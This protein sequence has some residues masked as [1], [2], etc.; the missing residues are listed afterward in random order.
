VEL[1]RNLQV[2][3]TIPHPSPLEGVGGIS[4]KLKNSSSSTLP[5]IE[6]TATYDRYEK[7]EETVLEATCRVPNHKC[8]ATRAE[9]YRNLHNWY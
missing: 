9:Q 8:R 7:G 3:C 5:F 2:D 1:Q 6:I 4:R